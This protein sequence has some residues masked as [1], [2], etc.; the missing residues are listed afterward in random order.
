MFIC[1][2]ITALCLQG[3]IIMI[4]DRIKMVRERLG[5][6]RQEDFAKAIGLS[7][8]TYQT[9]EQGQVKNIPHSFILKLNEQYGVS[10]EWLLLGKGDMFTKDIAVDGTMTINTKDY[11]YGD[12]IKELLELLKDVPRSWIQNIT[13]KLKRSLEAFNGDFK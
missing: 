12:E 4:F 5:F 8:R 2:Y 11:T 10:F 7:F 9:Y 13:E 6:K 1:Q 3:S